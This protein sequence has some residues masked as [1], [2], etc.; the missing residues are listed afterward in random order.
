MRSVRRFYFYLVAFVSAQVIIWGVISL[1]RT[2]CD[3]A[4]GAATTNLLASGLSLVLVGVPIFLLHWTVT[5]RDA[6]QDEAERFS[7]LRALFLYAI[8]L[9]V[10]L[11]TV[12]NLLALLN[13]G[14]LGW[15]GVSPNLALIGG[16]QGWEDNL[17]AV[18]VNLIAW[19]CFERALWLD[20]RD[21]EDATSL[22]ELRRLYRFVWLL[23]GLTLNVIGVVQVLRFVFHAAFE[24]AG[25]TSLPWLGNGLAFMLAGA[26][27]WIWVW[28]TLQQAACRDAEEK[29]SILR[30]AILYLLAL[31]SAFS[32]LISAS[33]FISAGLR[34]ALGENQA[35]ADFIFNNGALLSFVIPMGVVWAYFGKQRALQVQSESDVPRRAGLQ[36]LYG[37]ALSLLGTLTT[38]LGL[39]QLTF[40]MIDMLVDTIVIPAFVR[41]PLASGLALLAVGLPVWLASW[42]PL[43]TEAHRMDD[44]GDHARRSV[45]RKGYLYLLLFACVVG[46]MVSAGM[47]FYHL[48]SIMLGQPYDEPVR[49]LAQSGAALLLVTNWLVYHLLALR[50]DGRQAQLALGEEHAAFPTLIVQATEHG[51]F[52][53]QVA[54]A[55]KRTAP[56]LPVVIHYLEDVPGLLGDLGTVK[57]VVMPAEVALQLD[58]KDYA[59]QRVVVPLH[60]EKYIWCGVARRKPAE[61][62]EE[63]ARSV[64]LLAEGQPVSAPGGAWMI[65]GY[66]LAGLVGLQILSILGSILFSLVID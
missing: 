1:A 15:I 9:A 61:L 60:A 53:E 13:R 11:P 55:L 23:Y 26:P 63:A 22:G 41:A 33:V 36:R 20:W 39:L 48:I 3:V 24:G 45:V 37:Y 10:L 62:V 2:L 25:V 7:R 4:P 38:F 56:R 40:A 59:G 65:V 58:L 31:A 34:W 16:G 54:L 19:A 46:I 28:V 32:V 30:V 5:Q 6:R 29:R 49:V 18:V 17:A 8:R 14:L 43:Q 57:A 64:R 27:L 44:A 21:A 52:T 35:A 51:G 42:R 47:L 66:I 12:Q 50:G